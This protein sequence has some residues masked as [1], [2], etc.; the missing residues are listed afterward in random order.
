MKKMKKLLLIACVL[1]SGI[2]A[3][4]AQKNEAISNDIQRSVPIRLKA[5]V[6]SVPAPLN[7]SRASGDVIFQYFD[8][9]AKGYKTHTVDYIGVR[10]YYYNFSVNWVPETVYHRV[11]LE[12]TTKPTSGP[13]PIVLVD[14][15]CYG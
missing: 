13:H 5:T 6:V 2:F 4:Y 15:K 10:P 7:T 9:Y 3:S 12:L 11:K 8:T 1:T 14:W